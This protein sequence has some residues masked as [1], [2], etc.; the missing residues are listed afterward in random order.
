M[1]G[2]PVKGK[3]G[4]KRTPQPAQPFDSLLPAVITAHL[5]LSGARNTNFDLV[6]VF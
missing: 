4:W 2:R 5:K 3:A 1:S 6:T